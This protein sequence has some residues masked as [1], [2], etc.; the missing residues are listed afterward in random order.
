MLGC[1]EMDIRNG[2][3]LD[4]VIFVEVPCYDFKIIQQST[5][6]PFSYSYAFG[7]IYSSYFYTF[8]IIL[9]LLLDPQFLRHYLHHSHHQ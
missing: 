1:T 4:I 3:N 2:I 5:L 9:F 7:F 8:G 6:P